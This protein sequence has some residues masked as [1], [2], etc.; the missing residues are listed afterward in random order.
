MF[1]CFLNQPYFSVHLLCTFNRTNAKCLASAKYCSHD[2][3]SAFAMSKL[4]CL[5]SI[6]SIHPR[7]EL[8]QLYHCIE[9][10]MIS[11]ECLFFSVHHIF[12]VMNR[13]IFTVIKTHLIPH[14]FYVNL[15]TA[16]KES[17]FASVF[18]SLS[19]QLSGIDLAQ[20]SSLWL[21]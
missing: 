13:T 12:I 5:F 3:C 10:A 2:H 16:L 9:F 19:S 1:S 20:L 17:I 4:M 6:Q 14:L 7:G 18:G 21:L 15:F 11:L 8:V